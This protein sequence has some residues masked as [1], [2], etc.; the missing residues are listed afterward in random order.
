AITL[1]NHTI[2]T[3]TAVFAL[4]PALRI[5]EGQGGPGDFGLA[6]LFAAFTACMELPAA[7]VAGALGAILFCE[8]A[9]R[10]LLFLVPPGL[11]VVAAFFAVNYIA[12]GQW[13]PAYSEFGG[14]WYEY[15]GSHW[16]RPLPG[17]VRPGIDWAWTQESRPTYWIH[18]FIGHHGWFALTPLWLLA[19]W[20]MTRVS[21]AD[22]RAWVAEARA[23]P[24][25]GESSGR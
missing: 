20:G 10:R 23:G 15:E 17:E 14:P 18:F 8:A 16:R 7:A 12:V 1:N 4:Y 5:L 19:V 22:V 21:T 13:R 3:F 25:N 24:M 2:A 6:G 9:G 11:I